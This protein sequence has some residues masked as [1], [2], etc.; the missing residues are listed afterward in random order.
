MLKKLSGNV[1][2]AWLYRSLQIPVQT[3]HLLYWLFNVKQS[4]YNY[5]LPYISK[6]GKQKQ[7]TENRIYWPE[8]RHIARSH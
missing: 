2:L 3:A 6:Y 5:D 1:I 7:Q 8:C 4:A